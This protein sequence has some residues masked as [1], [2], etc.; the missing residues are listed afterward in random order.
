MEIP[1][2]SFMLFSLFFT[3]I[4]CFWS[5]HNG[6]AATLFFCVIPAVAAYIEY[7]KV[8]VGNLYLLIYATYKTFTNLPSINLCENNVAQ[9][10]VLHF[11]DSEREL[12]TYLLGNI[13]LILF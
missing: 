11:C 12:L 13:I 9:N 6:N 2:I 3:Q 4:F 1:T 7:I 5:N 8:W 10:F